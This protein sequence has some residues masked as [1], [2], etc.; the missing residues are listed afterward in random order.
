MAKIDKHAYYE[1]LLTTM[2]LIGFELETPWDGNNGN[3]VFSSKYGFISFIPEKFSN[4]Y[5]A[6]NI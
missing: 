1:T 6:S 4:N 3:I 2:A 5:I